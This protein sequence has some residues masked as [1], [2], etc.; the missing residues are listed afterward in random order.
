MIIDIH[1]HIFP[2]AIAAKTL[3]KLATA[4]CVNPN[5]DGTA[6]GLCA[7]MKRAG[8]DYCVT[9]PAVTNPNK[10]QSINDKQID[11]IESDLKMG[12][13]PFAGMHPLFTGYK[14]EMKRLR[15]ADI[16][17]IKL[18]PAYQQIDF[19]APE[20]MRIVDAASNEGLLTIVHGGIDIG[21]YDHNYSS[22]K[23]ILKVIDTVHPT[24]LIMAHMG[25]WGNWEEVERDL[26]GAPVY[27]DTA[28]SI[29]TIHPY[30]DAP[31][32]P[33]ANATLDNNL[34]LRIL[35]KHGSDKILF[36]TDSPWQDQAEYL[37]LFEE[38]PLTDD[39]RKAI[40]GE[41]AKRLLKL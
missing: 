13:L 19:D 18:H 14:E 22:V 7:S 10:V 37:Q 35:R 1:T 27:L 28:F 15:A 31:S 41:N 29:G 4:A 3:D 30:K 5:T 23:H 25:N 8:V 38:L 24:G 17:G 9:L 11:Y 21:I 12:I 26:V 34:F 6:E 40:L 2:S 32:S 16:K 39:E 36:G 33:Y 20:M